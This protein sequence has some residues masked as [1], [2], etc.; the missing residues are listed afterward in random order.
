MVEGRYDFC[1]KS[2][3]KGLEMGYVSVCDWFI[4]PLALRISI[5]QFILDH[6]RR[7]QKRNRKEKGKVL[8]LAIPIPTPFYFICTG[9]KG[10]LCF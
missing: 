9:K 5:N 4:L 8:I 6:K 7:N 1:S 10:S 2:R 3:I